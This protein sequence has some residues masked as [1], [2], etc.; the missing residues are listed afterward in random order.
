MD[1]QHNLL[2]CSL[3]A[4]ELVDR[5]SAWGE[6]EPAILD[7]TRIDGGFR[8]RFHPDPKVRRSLRALVDAESGCCGW[9]SWELTDEADHS[10]LRVTGP[11]ERMGG[12]AEAFGL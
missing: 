1:E 10:V 4:P 12:L 7:R 6:V 8:V 11:P 5:R 2:G 9:A 3:S